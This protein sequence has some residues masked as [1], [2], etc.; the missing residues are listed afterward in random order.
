METPPYIN[1][2]HS[3]NLELE[4]NLKNAKRDKEKQE[5]LNQVKFSF[6]NNHIQ[7]TDPLFVS[8]SNI[9]REAGFTDG[10]GHQNFTFLLA[11][12][13]RVLF[14]VGELQKNVK[15]GGNEVVLKY[16]F[17]LAKDKKRAKQILLADPNLQRF[18]RS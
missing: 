5:L 17:T 6:H 12:L 18:R 13:K 7:G 11:S 15:I 16:H 8:V 10:V 14:P 3:Q 2:P 4:K 1:T 9:F